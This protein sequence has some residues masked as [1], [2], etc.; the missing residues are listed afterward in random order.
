MAEEK[1]PDIQ[2]EPKTS[3]KN[4]LMAILSYLGPLVIVSYIAA[5]DEPF[6]KFHIRQ[7]LILL[8]LWVAV[9]FAS[10]TFWWFG[11]WMIWNLVRFALFVFAVIG[12]VNAVQG[13][14]K[15]LPLIGS[16]ARYLTF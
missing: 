9:W 13:K 3:E 1:A 2:M 5:K 6:V 8:I 10:S 16:F 11:L 14:E 7:G 12:I 4:T 15:G